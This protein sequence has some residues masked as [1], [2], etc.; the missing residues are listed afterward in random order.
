M[1]VETSAV[2]VPLL[3]SEK[4]LPEGVDP[5]RQ[6]RLVETALNTGWRV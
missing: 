6:V 3:Y 1:E 5:N 2:L 4:D